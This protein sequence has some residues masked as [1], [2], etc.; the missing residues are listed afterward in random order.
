MDRLIHGVITQKRSRGRVSKLP[1]NLLPGGEKHSGFSPHA[2][3]T[4]HGVN[5]GVDIFDRVVNRKR[6]RVIAIFLSFL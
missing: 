6:L 4:A 2:V 1:T 3:P 5:R